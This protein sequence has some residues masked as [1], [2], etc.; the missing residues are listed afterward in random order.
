MS[1]FFDSPVRYEEE[2]EPTYEWEGPPEAVVAATV[3]VERVVAR[4]DA[5]AVY[6]ASISALPRGFTFD[7]FV[8]LATEDSGLAPFHPEYEM[9]GQRTGEIPAEKL[10][11]GFL[12]GD[13]S[14]ATNTGRYFGWYEESGEPPDAPVM[15]NRGGGGG[16][17]R[18]W[19]QSFWV[20]PLPSPG[21]FEFLCEWPA[22][23]IPLTRV[24][25]DATPV[26]DAASR[27][28]ERFPDT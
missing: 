6:L 24:E 28:R 12:F 23:A 19:H 18:S 13:G 16:D 25:L 4:N 7:V 9:L 21:S 2:P 8:A 22:A 1:E 26:I 20:W 15:S 11:V 5:V 10:R 14:K 3:P 17:M 27:C